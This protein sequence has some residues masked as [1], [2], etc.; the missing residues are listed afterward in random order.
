MVRLP[1][2]KK[3]KSKAVL[4]KTI[5]S[6]IFTPELRSGIAFYLKLFYNFNMVTI[7][8]PTKI[9]I[10]T[11]ILLVFSAVYLFMPNL[12][13]N[14]NY[15]ENP[16]VNLI[17]STLVSFGFKTLIAVF[18]V[19][20]VKLVLK[21]KVG[22]TK[23]QFV[24]GFFGYG[25]IM[26][27]YC[28]G[29]FFSSFPFAYQGEGVNYSTALK[30]IPIYFVKCLGIGIGEEAVW[31]ILGVNLFDWAI[32]REKKGRFF[33]VLIPSII[34]GVAHLN[35]L[36]SNPTL[37]NKTVAQVFY[38]AMI[39]VYF[40]VCYYKS[41]NI[42]PCILLHALFDFA[43]YVCRGFYPP[44]VLKKVVVTDTSVLGAIYTVAVNVPLL[45]YAILLFFD[46][47]KKKENPNLHE[48]K[49]EE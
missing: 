15:S 12:Y 4:I 49:A 7:K 11:L 30:L 17:V 13:N 1:C 22:I 40:S 21:R 27:A 33:I 35:N 47:F 24:L 16:W 10:A 20:L 32:G 26:L 44:E 34:F 25:A 5:S 2:G 9:L 39:G 46:F 38:A 19:L 14:I 41:E 45:I 3:N 29:N 8:K 36:I 18:A 43:Y 23:K 31:R 48:E 42:L 37:I 28:V 6:I